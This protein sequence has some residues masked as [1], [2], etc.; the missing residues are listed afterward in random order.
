LFGVLR[1]YARYKVKYLGNNLELGGPAVIFALVIFGGFY[2]GSPQDTFDITV[3]VKGPDGQILKRAS[4][5]I[6][7]EINAEAETFRRDKSLASD[8]EVIFKNIPSKFQNTKISVRPEGVKGYEQ[9][10]Q[11]FTLEGENYIEL[12]LI[13]PGPMRLIGR[14][15]PKIQGVKVVVE[16]GGRRGNN[17]RVREFR[18]QGQRDSRR[19]SAVVRL[20]GRQRG[21]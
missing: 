9:K 4:G 19:A 6:Y 1:S 5:R 10:Q 14:V 16:G 8:G 11:D 15:V 18:F 17:R 12:K 13:R 21:V 2:F 7:I 3:Y 20:P